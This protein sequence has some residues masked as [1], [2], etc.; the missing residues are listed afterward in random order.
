[1]T[2]TVQ[3]ASGFHWQS[4]LVTFTHT[5]MHTHIHIHIYAHDSSLCRCQC[6]CVVAT[7]RPALTQLADLFV[8]NGFC[9]DAKV[10]F[11]EPNKACVT[12]NTPAT[13]WGGRA[14][15]LRRADPINCFLLKTATELLRRAGYEVVSSSVEY[16]GLLEKTYLTYR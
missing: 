13:I 1:M 11:P 15:Q 16:D 10:A 9:W 5:H 3:C 12:L 6:S 14:L 7:I 8:L 4:C 2:S